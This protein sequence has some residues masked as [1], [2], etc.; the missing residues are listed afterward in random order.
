MNN[1]E[2]ANPEELEAARNKLYA[3]INAS[4]NE[5]KANYDVNFQ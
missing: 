4:D 1:L 5:V 3:L 2:G